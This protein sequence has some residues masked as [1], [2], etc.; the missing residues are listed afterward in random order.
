MD[1]LKIVAR[2]AYSRTAMQTYLAPDISM[3]QLRSLLP[4]LGL[5]ITEEKDGGIA[6]TDGKNYLWAYGTEEVSFNRYGGNDPEEILRKIEEAA[7][8]SI[9]AVN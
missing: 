5:S 2:V 8:I 7:G 1:I 4:Q 3:E 6:I 9:E